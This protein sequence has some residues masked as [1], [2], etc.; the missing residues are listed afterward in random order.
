MIKSSRVVAAAA[1]VVLSANLCQATVRVRHHYHSHSGFS[2]GLAPGV[3]PNAPIPDQLEYGGSYGGGAGFSH[4]S[5]GINS[6][7]NDFGTSGV[8]GHTNGMP[9]NTYFH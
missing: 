5:G 3:A 7:G 4:E 2:A 8:L 9:V 1:L 6:Q